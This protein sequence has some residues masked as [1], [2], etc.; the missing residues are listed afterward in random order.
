MWHVP[1]VS[2]D[3]DPHFSR[4]SEIINLCVRGTVDMRALTVVKS[5]GRREEAVA[6]EENMT[7]A[8]ESARAIGCQISDNTHSKLLAGDKNASVQILFDLVKVGRDSG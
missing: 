2:I 4:L 1:C 6:R 8:V 7:L 5:G 3:F